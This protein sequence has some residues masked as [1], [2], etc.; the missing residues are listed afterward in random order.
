MHGNPR[1]GPVSVRGTDDHC[2]GVFFLKWVLYIF[3]FI[4]LVTLE[5]SSLNIN[6]FT[7]CSLFFLPQYVT[8]L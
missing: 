1:M 7:E 6:Q 5:L 8:R 4:L 2:C 3:N